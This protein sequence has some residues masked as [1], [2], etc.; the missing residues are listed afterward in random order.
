MT[1]EEHDGPATLLYIFTQEALQL[2]VP[3]VSAIVRDYVTREKREM[4]ARSYVSIARPAEMTKWNNKKRQEGIEK[5]GISRVCRA[6]QTSTDERKTALSSCGGRVARVVI[7]NF[8]DYAFFLCPRVVLG[9]QKA[10]R[11]K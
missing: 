5:I 9:R 7:R 11:P 8:Y 3:A 1:A 6:K 4:R 10:S 2:G